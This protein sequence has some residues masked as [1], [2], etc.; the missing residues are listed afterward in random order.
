MKDEKRRSLSSVHP[1]SFILHPSSVFS[2]CA[3]G[4]G[5]SMVA[6]VSSMNDNGMVLSLAR[7]A[8]MSNETR[9]P[10]PPAQPP[11]HSDTLLTLKP[12]TAPMKTAIPEAELAE[13][14]APT[15][16]LNEASDF[17]PASADGTLMTKGDSV[18][19]AALPAM[20]AALV[21]GYD[22]LEE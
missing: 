6:S 13:A 22:I 21:P 19:R 2:S 12:E 15:K 1:S 9:S 20:G 11:A 18:P 16:T 14:A 10:H 17:M 4:Q 8:T 5:E 7:G 3:R